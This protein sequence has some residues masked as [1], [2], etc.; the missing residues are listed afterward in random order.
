[1]KKT[2]KSIKDFKKMSIV[3]IIVLFIAMM[4]FNILYLVICDYSST[5]DIDDYFFVQLSNTILQYSPITFI[6]LAGML[7]VFITYKNRIT[8]IT[9]SLRALLIFFTIAVEARFIVI[10]KFDFLFFISLI[11]ILS[12]HLVLYACDL[13]SEKTNNVSNASFLPI[14]GDESLFESR[15]SQQ[16]SFID[17][18]QDDIINNGVSV[19]ITGK[20]GCGKTSFVNATL[21]KIRNQD[22]QFEEIIIKTLELENIS[23]LIRYFFSR[24]KDILEKN[25]I[26]S[27]IKSEYSAL[28]HSFVSST[29]NKNFADLFMSKFEYEKDYRGSL[30]KIDNLLSES[31]GNNRII[32]VVDDIERC[33]SEKTKQIIFFIKEIATLS[34]CIS[35]FLIDIDKLCKCDYFSDNES[36][37]EEFVDKF[38]DI[39]IELNNVGLIENV[40]RFNN[41][42]FADLIKGI[43]DYYEQINKKCD[44][45]IVK[46]S[47]LNTNGKYQ[48]N[49]DNEMLKKKEI[50]NNIDDLNVVFCNPR[51][52]AKIYF[53]YNN[54]CNKIEQLLDDWKER[55]GVN[56]EKAISFFNNINYKKQ[57][58]I[59]SILRD[60]F[61]DL[62]KNILEKNIHTL[63]IDCWLKEIIILEWEPLTTNF[64][65]FYKREYSNA[66][67]KNDSE[68]LK[69]IINP[70]SNLIDEY[71]SY[72]KDNSIPRH[73]GNEVSYDDCFTSIHSSEK[74][75]R[76]IAEKMFAVYS[77]NIS[78]DEAL[79]PFLNNNIIHAT[80]IALYEFAEV[81][82]DS[83][84]RIDNIDMC[85]KNF[86]S[87]LERILWRLLNDFT[88]YCY[89]LD[90]NIRQDISEL[91]YDKETVKENL[92]IFF[93]RI[94]I[95]LNSHK[96]EKNCFDDLTKLLDYIEDI[97]MYAKIKL[98]HSTRK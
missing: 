41:Q 22:I 63:K 69:E 79:I 64:F 26:Y 21:D 53:Y 10:K 96:I 57:N 13:I 93:N 32:I 34:K 78:F 5:K 30:V 71:I 76:L 88:T 44:E 28:V 29:T 52:M 37:A 42:E 50:T 2:N 90:E 80:E 27:G 83:K 1:M 36:V 84:I 70:F 75:N 77:S 56:K 49:L 65:T 95:I 31:L 24:I 92:D 23:D 20:W 7:S 9:I 35:L 38:F 11:E 73:N 51:R 74:F 89:Y 8:N 91:I 19:C 33:S 62:Y 85:K 46:Y 86:S 18:I 66:I 59:I 81:F 94:S 12:T 68:L 60:C 25:N 97:Y 67:I 3:R 58:V 17:L 72:I 14:S 47:N 16:N 15:K 4:V 87:R 45:E 82:C 43:S 55:K 39:R 40:D 6:L 54:Y 48:K 98:S 61:Y